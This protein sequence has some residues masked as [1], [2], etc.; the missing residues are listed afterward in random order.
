MI[1]II[2]LTKRFNGH[3]VLNSVNLTVQEGE[4]MVIIGRSG[5]GKTVLLK[6]MIGLIQPDEGQVLV[7]GQ[8]IA[9]L[10]GREMDKVRLKFGMLFQGAGLFDSLTVGENV[11]FS[12]REHTQMAEE[13]IAERVQECLGLV[14]LRGIEHFKPA[15]LSGGMRKRVGLARA[16]AMQ[17]K[18]I[19]YDEPTT[20][21]DPI[22]ADGINRLIQQL[23][24]K[25]GVTGVAVTHDIVSAYRIADRIAMLHEG[26]IIQVGTPEQIRNSS[27]T[28][29]KRFVQGI[30]EA[31]A[32]PDAVK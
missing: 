27:N 3:T 29:V 7:E 1:E 16:L 22:G 25:L 6:H 4:T 10:S 14:G 30:S 23:H 18:I 17:P 9:R 2:N 8:E 31:S 21:V 11:A 28:V 5:C 13:Q 15:E 19:L 26:K 20:G 32:P 12:L 24:D